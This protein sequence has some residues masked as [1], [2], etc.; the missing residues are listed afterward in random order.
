MT[1]QVKMSNNLKY[2]LVL[3]TYDNIVFT[4]DTV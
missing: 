2:Q 3:S 4:P 1:D